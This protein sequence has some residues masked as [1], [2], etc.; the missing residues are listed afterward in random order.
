MGRLPQL[1]AAV[2]SVLKQMPK[3]RRRFVQEPPPELYGEYVL[4]LHD[5]RSLL[6]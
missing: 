2:E 1:R 3:E 5:G 4:V 6:A